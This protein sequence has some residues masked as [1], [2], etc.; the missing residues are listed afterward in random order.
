MKNLHEDLLPPLKESKPGKWFKIRCLDGSNV[1]EGRS[2]IK[3]MLS[4]AAVEIA[5][6]TTK[7]KRKLPLCGCWPCRNPSVTGSIYCGVHTNS[8][9]FFNGT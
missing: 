2:A 5:P 8:L 9:T 3:Y 1:I 4:G 6:I 7:K